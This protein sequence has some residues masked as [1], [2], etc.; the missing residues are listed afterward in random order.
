[1]DEERVTNRLLDFGFDRVEAEAYLFL[2]RAGFCPASLV[3][4]KLG[5]NRMKAYRILKAL[6]ERGLVEVIIGRPVKFVATP[7]KEA[8]DQKI[9]EV[10]VKVSGLEKSKE[11]IMEYWKNL[12]NGVKPSVEEPRFRIFQG[13]QQ[14]YDLILKMFE[15]AK[16]EIR[17]ITT[18]ND[19]DRLF[20]SGMDDKLKDL[21]DD[22]VR[23]RVLTQVDEQMLE[24]LENYL[25][26]AEIRH[27]PFPTTMRF[28]IID[29]SEVLTTFAM[30]DSM[31][32][33]TQRD[34]GLWTNA[35][36]YVK[37]MKTFFDAQWG[38]A[39]DA[40]EVVNA[41]KV[42]ISPGK[43]RIIGT[44]EE[45]I[46][47]YKDMIESSTEEIIIL[48]NQLQTLPITIEGLQ[49][50]SDRGIK[51]R[52]L[53]QVDFNSLTDIKQ[54]LRLAQVKHD[55]TG[56]N[57]RLLIIDRE[58]VMVHIP[59]WEEMGQAI[60]SNLKDYVD[61][62]LQVFED[63]WVD[64]IPAQEILPR[65]LSQQV[66]ME[67]LKL[68]KKALEEAGWVVE[69]PGRV[70]GASG[71]E[72]S[73]SLVAK[74]LVQPDRPLVLDMLVE[75]DAI[76]QIVMLSVKV[77]DVKPVVQLLASNRPLDEGEARL[78]D[79]YGIRPI[80]AADAQQLPTKIME[81]ANRILK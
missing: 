42:G 1:L 3:A 71:V 76:G 38:V 66:F 61:A 40:R 53:T 16:V 78:A 9:E 49:A 24:S 10:R 72:H 52:L 18:G 34:I 35:I 73:F 7:I 81:E 58:E 55:T 26:F 17:L 13:R 60:W 75:E 15:N 8:L 4:R 20:L 56:I 5:I 27:I 2:L 29:E 67:S 51:I 77:R 68:A 37:A 54:I 14:V 64:G 69:V 22:G 31:S 6:E 25:G 12:T 39:L 62:M 32:M 19:L 11:D 74:S 43:I 36:N 50:A 45:Y 28:I 63:R 48:K 46:K 79:L 41:V 47:T 30:D 80:Y 70:V 23:T 65:F 59:R 33:T 57:L 21:V 44:N